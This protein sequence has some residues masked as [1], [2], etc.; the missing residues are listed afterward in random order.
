LS[1]PRASVADAAAED[2]GGRSGGDGVGNR[3]GRLTVAEFAAQLADRRKREDAAL[4]AADPTLGRGAATTYRD[5]ETGHRIGAEAGSIREQFEKAA[6]KKGRGLTPAEAEA[7]RVDWATGAAQKRAAAAAARAL[8]SARSMAMTV[9]ADDAG[10]DAVL[11][12][13]S[14]KD[15]PMAAVLARADAKRRASE[16]RERGSD[17][18]SAEEAP[19]RPEY[20][21]PEPPPTRYGRAVRPGYRWDGVDRGNGHERRLLGNMSRPVRR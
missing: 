11:R 2:R 13:R 14:R 19:G 9:G 18:D 21:G 1:A 3:T 12:A 4:I 8:E 7:Q 17:F 20:T 6:R 16:R 5:A 15:D 10:V